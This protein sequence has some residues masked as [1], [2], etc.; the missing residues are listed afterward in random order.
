MKRSEMISIIR[1]SM[2]DGWIKPDE[3]LH[4]IEEAGMLPPSFTK[5]EQITE[6]DYC[7]VDGMI[8]VKR[9]V[10]SFINKWEEE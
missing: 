3:I 6:V 9:T 2:I 1:Q 10:Y 4:F 5:S 8:N 7:P